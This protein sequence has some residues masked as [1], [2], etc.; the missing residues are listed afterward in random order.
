[1]KLLYIN[2][3]HL[4]VKAHR[5][6]SQVV[7]EWL[8][9][10]AG[11]SGT[12]CSCPLQCCHRD[13]RDTCRFCHKN[14]STEQRTVYPQ[15]T[16]KVSANTN[17]VYCFA[18]TG[19]IRRKRNKKLEILFIINCIQIMIKIQFLNQA[20]TISTVRLIL[21]RKIIFVYCEGHTR[22]AST[23]C[24]RILSLW[25]LLYGT[26]CN[27]TDWHFDNKLKYQ[28][29]LYLCSP[30]HTYWNILC[31]MTHDMFDLYRNLVAASE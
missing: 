23:E 21:C 22:H 1:M 7:P 12:R 5:P 6:S 29:E 30:F 18:I 10:H 27:F 25:M 2:V 8:A 4:E 19:L 15:W 28:S 14:G 31:L 16:L 17:L 3:V 11:P 24:G 26:H 13:R 20:E 9:E